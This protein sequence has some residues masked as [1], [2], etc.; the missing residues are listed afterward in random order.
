M[1]IREINK[2]LKNF[3]VLYISQLSDHNALSEYIIKP[4]IQSRREEININEIYKSIIL[5]H[6]LKKDNNE[7]LI[8]DY[9]LKGFSVIINPMEEEYIVCNTKEIQKRAIESPQL[10]DGLRVPKDSFTENMD[11]NLSLIRYRIKDSNLRIKHFE[12]GIRTKTSVSLIYLQDVAN[13]K[14]IEITE[15]KLNSIE[16]DGVLE[17]GYLQKFFKNKDLEF[18]PQTSLAERSDK[19]SASILTGAACVLVEGSGLAL[20]IPSTIGAFIDSGD[21]HYE[22]YYISVFNKLLRI[23]CIMLTLTAAPLYVAIVAYNSD[24]IPF[25]YIL[26]LSYSRNFV[27]VNA[28]LEAFIME[29]ISKILVESSIR[30][31][32][33]I[34]PAIG[35]VGA[36][37]IGQAAVSAGL[38]SPL[39]VI[40]VA[41]STMAS[42]VVP[43]YS[44]MDSINLLKFIILIITGMLGLYGFII[45]CSFII[46]ALVSH[47]NFSI[48]Y[49]SPFAPFNWIDFKDFF[50]SSI[51]MDKY[52]RLYIKPKNK[53]R[54]K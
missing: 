15:K 13:D 7:N 44:L 42:F 14:I 8:I 37:V 5:V 51:K 50:L 20:I 33:K 2:E 16:V 12:I 53:R 54:T 40:I 25:K 41:L 21:D 24:V 36:I 3:F 31:P 1:N 34:G 48:P 11:T 18:F 17:G 10:Q 52:R 46:L 28:F 29:I 27:P 6:D 23:G 45:A 47:N 9:V 38:V 39:M 26:T 4:I 22:P 30:F 32:K 35:I 43:D 49:G 19:A